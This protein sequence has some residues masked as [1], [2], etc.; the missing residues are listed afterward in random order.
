[1]REKGIGKGSRDICP[2]RSLPKDTE[3]KGVAQRK[4]AG[5]KSARGNATLG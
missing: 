3:D 2:V 5:C 1:M 4:T